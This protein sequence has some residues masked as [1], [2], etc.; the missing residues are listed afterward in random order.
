MKDNNKLDEFLFLVLRNLYNN[1]IKYWRMILG[2]VIF[3]IL[4][5]L[6]FKIEIKKTNAY[7]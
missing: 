1:K 7:S 5:M 2:N 3:F 4:C 6:A